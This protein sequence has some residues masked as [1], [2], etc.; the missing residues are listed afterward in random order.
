VR[1]LICQFEAEVRRVWTG[2]MAQA[3]VA[4]AVAGPWDLSGSASWTLTVAVNGGATQTLTILRSA[5]AIPAA[6]TPAEIAAL[7]N[8]AIADGGAYALTDDRVALEA[9][10]VAAGT[11][12]RVTG[13]TLNGVLAFPT[14]TEAQ[15]GYDDALGG[16]RPVDDGTPTGAAGRREH[17][18][19]TVRCQVDRGRWGEQTMTP[20]GMFDVAEV[21]LTLDM[22]D[23]ER[24]GL[25]R[26]DGA[27]RFTRGD[28]VT[29]IRTVDGIS[30]EAFDDLRVERIERAG[31]GLS[32]RRARPM[33]CYLHCAR[34]RV[35]P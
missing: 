15:A 30:V 26:A 34:D 1:W 14:G 32:L 5:L 9:D 11:T 18:A 24:M 23:L 29:A 8:A 16:V 35:A 6:A 20:G 27:P 3:S 4:S 33:L 25:T 31:H 17:A 7:L 13:G 10:L 22:R 2:A 19:V 21:V 28:R 12:I